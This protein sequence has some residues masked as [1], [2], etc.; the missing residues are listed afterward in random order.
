MEKGRRSPSSQGARTW[1][2]ASESGES[3]R[4]MGL[5][6]T[7]AGTGEATHFL[8]L[9]EVTVEDMRQLGAQAG[10]PGHCHMTLPYP[11]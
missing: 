9:Q 2:A 5:T 8:T 3:G 4:G 11:R 1:E 10:N 7:T 6:R